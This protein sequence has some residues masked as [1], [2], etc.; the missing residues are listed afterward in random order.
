MKRWVGIVTV[1]LSGFVFVGAGCGGGGQTSGGPPPAGS[2][3][4]TGAPA[5]ELEGG[6]V[7]VDIKDL[8]FD[9]EELN[10]PA[11]ATV[12]WTNSDHV[13]HTVTKV[14]GPD[15]PDFDSG[16]LEPGSTFSQ[17]F[18][19]TGRYEIQDKDRPTTEM[20]IEVERDQIEQEP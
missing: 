20:T 8:R 18:E 6:K 7:A 11:G 19:R 13:S 10:I 9:P 12:V 4:V 17:V 5:G 2:S 1:V 3:P 14:G 15:E 16:P